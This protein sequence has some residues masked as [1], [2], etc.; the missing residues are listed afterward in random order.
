[1]A[2]LLL[3]NGNLVDPS[4]GIDTESD[5]LIVEGRIEKIGRNLKAGP[6]VKEMDLRGKVVSPGF[7]DMHVHFR[8]PGF[9]HKET[10]ATGCASAAA[11]GFTG[12]CCMPNTN[13]PIDDAT[14]VSFIHEKG[15]TALNGAVDVFC[16]G[17][18]TKGR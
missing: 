7:F 11:G 16:I 15:R 3:K 1:M 6:G 9:E 17:A 14:V 13:P 10:I 8:E 4:N 12:V 18:V 2:T 5:L